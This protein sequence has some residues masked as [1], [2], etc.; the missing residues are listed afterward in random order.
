MEFGLFNS[1]CVLPQFAG[2]EHRRI[3][4]EVA[5]VE[6]ADKVGFKYTWA[7][8]HHFLTQY[9][10]LSANE[11]FLGYLAAATSNI[12]LG[13]GIFNV[14]PPVNHP[15]RVAERVALLDH[16]SEGRFEFGMGRGSSTTEQKGFGI[17]DPDLT[18]D[19]FGE[20]VGEFRKMW[21]AEEYP[22]F[23]GEFFSMPQRNVLPKPYSEPH[24]PMWVAAGNPSTFEKAARMGLG[25]LCF[26]IGGVDS[27]KP[28]VELYKREIENA[29]PVGDFVN[30]NI[31]V[32]TQLL[33]LEDGQRVRD[34]GS[35]LGMGYHRS[36]LLRY[37]DTFP[38]PAG[39]PEW[40]AI[41][42]DPTPEMIAAG[43]AMGEMPY[44]TPE[45]VER[46]IIRYENAGVDQV[47]FGLLSST[48]DRELAFETIETFGKQVLPRFDT[49]PVHRS[50]RQRE[51]FVR[52]SEA[53]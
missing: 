50:T 18:R 3:M 12:H 43:I 41:L 49:D 51:A 46:S 9:S 25:V 13:S 38:K 44:G 52:E 47:V 20:V 23:D 29:E 32:T 17:P 33:C 27:V 37:L 36:L 42:P 14:T 15:A 53:S 1:A 48:M 16:L 45:E 34:L 22:G 40:P 30:D 19:M 2:D 26:T 6:C 31:M 8:E 4:D 21:R 7:T 11:V 10:H 28:L 35:R 24:P 5:I 39:V